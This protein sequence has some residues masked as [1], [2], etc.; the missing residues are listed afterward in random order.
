MRAS[1]EAS[2]KAAADRWEP[3]LAEA[4]ESARDLAESIFAVVDALDSSASLRRALTDPARPADAKASLTQG[5]LGAKA[6]DAVVDLVA[7]MSRSRW[8]ADDDLAS[9]LEEIGTTSLL[10]AAESRGELERV[11]DELFRLGRSLIGAREL[12][13]A[14]SNRELPVEN[15]VALVDALLE[16]KVAPETELLVRRAATSMRERSVPNAIAHVGELA[17]ARRRRLVAAVTAAVPLTQGQLTRLGEILERA[18]GRSVQI[19]VGIDPEVVGGLRVQVGAEVV[20][21]TVL[22]KLEEARRRLA[23]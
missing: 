2:L 14:L 11:E 22:T 16:G 10:A 5:L 18:Y 23:G 8:S 4:G 20:D 13:I 15:R 9:A 3:V 6:P 21:A 19:N 7:G 1:S 12:R 17:A